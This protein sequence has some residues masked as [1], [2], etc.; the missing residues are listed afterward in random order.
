[1]SQKA[2]LLLVDDDANT[3]ASLSRA[4]RLAGHEATVCDNAA[5]ALELLRTE[6]FDVIFSDVVM[7]GKSGLEFLEEIKNAGV[8]APV[9]LISGKGNE[10][11][12]Q[13]LIDLG[14]FAYV[15]KP[16]RLIEIED[17]VAQAIAKRQSQEN[18]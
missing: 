1:M 17:V 6:N 13:Q 3:L 9:I 2:H 4:F 18:S 8:K 16:F 11:D 10:Q 7:P 14:A 15:S 5:R 12:P